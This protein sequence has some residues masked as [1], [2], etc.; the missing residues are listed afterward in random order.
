MTKLYVE[1]FY[2][3]SLFSESTTQEVTSKEN[4][5]L[6][7]RAFGYRFFEREE[8]TLEGGELLKGAN[9]NHSGMYYKGTLYTLEE[10]KQIPNTEILQCNMEMNGDKLVIKTIIGNWQPFTEKDT[11]IS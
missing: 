7:E 3:G 5:K 6:P 9:K 8:V 1:F 2:P 4:I 11:L 10:V